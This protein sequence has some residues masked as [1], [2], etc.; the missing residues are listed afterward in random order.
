MARTKS[1]L[2]GVEVDRAKRAH[3]CQASA[4]HRIEMGDLRLSVR[5]GRSWDRYCLACAKA[6]LDKDEKKILEIRG[7]LGSN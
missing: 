4:K 2:T 6:I 7:E 3:N 1:L 5:N